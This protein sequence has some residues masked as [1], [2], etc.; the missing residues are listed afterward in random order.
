MIDPK[1]LC[2]KHLIGEHGELHKHLPSFR[3]GHKV[4][5][6]F[7]PVVQIQFQG[8]LERH[9]AI[10]EEMLNRGMNHKSPLKDLPDF[11]KLYTQYY[12]LKVD[13][14]ISLTDLITRCKDCERNIP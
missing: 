11:K 5:G 4:E 12:D 2:N 14:R 6:R 3:K 13:K 9:D 1:L 10:A 8:Y 7:N